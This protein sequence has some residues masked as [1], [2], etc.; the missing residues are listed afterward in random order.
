MG[1]VL[2]AAL[3]VV[4]AVVPGERHGRPFPAPDDPVA[5]IGDAIRAA[6]ST[7]RLPPSRDAADA[8]A[9]YAARVHWVIGNLPADAAYEEVNRLLSETGAAPV[10][11]RHDGEPWHLH[12]HAPDAPWDLGWGASMSAALA[13]VMGEAAVERLGLC[14]APA[15]D[16]AY[17]DVSRN[18]T[19][20][21]CSTACQNRVK[22]AAFR[23]RKGARPP[24]GTGA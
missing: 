6:D 11:S 7:W 22:T 19:R 24:E 5:A 18:G 17:L 4:N 21:F 20:R 12:Y 1:P 8:L 15:C 3:A 14:T 23:A 9:R 16:R 13:I 10:L 2:A